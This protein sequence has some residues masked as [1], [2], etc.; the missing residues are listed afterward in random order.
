[1]VEKA[2]EVILTRDGGSCRVGFVA[3][4]SKIQYYSRLNGKVAVVSCVLKNGDSALRN[5]NYRN[6]GELYASVQVES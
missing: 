5:I 6:Y 3:R 1:M 2:V 4:Y